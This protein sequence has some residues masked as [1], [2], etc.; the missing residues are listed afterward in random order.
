MMQQNENFFF[1]LEIRALHN[2]SIAINSYTWSIKFQQMAD[3]S[4]DF[5][6][7]SVPENPQHFGEAPPDILN[8]EAGVH[9]IWFVS[10]RNVDGSP[11]TAKLIDCSQDT[12]EMQ[13]I[14]AGRVKMADRVVL[15]VR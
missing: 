8:N 9:V 15:N 1:H 6:P 11:V 2:R 14:F 12:R 5:F 4:C 3:G 7:I 10:R 13:E